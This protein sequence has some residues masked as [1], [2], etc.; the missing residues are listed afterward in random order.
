MF[1]LFAFPTAESGAEVKALYRLSECTTCS[2]FRDI[3]YEVTGLL[4]VRDAAFMVGLSMALSEPGDAT[5][6][7]TSTTACPAR[8][9][10]GRRTIGNL[11]LVWKA[12]QTA[13]ALLLLI[14]EKA[15]DD[16]LDGDLVRSLLLRAALGNS[17]VTAKKI[18][19]GTGISESFLALLSSSHRRLEQVGSGAPA[20][21]S[22]AS[23]CALMEIGRLTSDDPDVLIFLKS[24]GELV[25]WLDAFRD[26]SSDQATGAC[27][28]LFTVDRDVSI[29]YINVCVRRAEVAVEG[30]PPLAK[31]FA[32]DYA[33]G[34][35]EALRSA[36]A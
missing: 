27:N 8:A 4:A 26:L 5:L 9:Y 34:L 3:G 30:F 11:R 14:R 21:W 2:A 10:L 1:G 17:E 28:P 6:E 19:H 15:S 32:M 7:I 12:H 36:T 18:L 23:G 22:E 20:A 31:S 24:I 25:Y 35:V 29:R 33:S 16:F 13:A